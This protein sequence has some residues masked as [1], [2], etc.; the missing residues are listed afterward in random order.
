MNSEV[1]IPYV[2]LKPLAKGSAKLR[3]SQY[4]KYPNLTPTQA[5]SVVRQATKGSK[6]PVVIDL[7]T[8]SAAAHDKTAQ[9]VAVSL[10]SSHSV[11]AINVKDKPQ[12]W[13]QILNV[14]YSLQIPLLAHNLVFD[15]AWII[16]DFNPDAK[17]FHEYRFHNFVGCTYAMY[18]HLASE[19]F[20]G[21][22][23]SLDYAQKTLLLID[24]NKIERNKKLVEQGIIKKNIK[25]ETLVKL[26]GHDNLE[27]YS[28][29]CRLN[30]GGCE[31][32]NDIQLE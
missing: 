16:R 2:I 7:E 14:L 10:A 26:I 1:R 6:T 8:T 3:T 21:Q 18:R 11:I 23:W 31:D 29:L 28:R 15:A 24:S 13:L 32:D 20:H 17:Y 9:V 5:Q 25:S 4:V 22:K 12:L 30:D 27:E 19:G